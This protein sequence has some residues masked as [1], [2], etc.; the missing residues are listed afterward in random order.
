MALDS[1]TS[2]TP[3]NTPTTPGEWLTTPRSGASAKKP[4]NARGPTFETGSNHH[5]AAAA[6]TMSATE[7]SSCHAARPGDGSATTR[8]AARA[9]VRRPAHT[10][11]KAATSTNHI[12]AAARSTALGTCSSGA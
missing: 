12:A 9:N 2:I 8:L 5:N 11:S 7:T 4:T 1:V 10:A 3:S 6:N